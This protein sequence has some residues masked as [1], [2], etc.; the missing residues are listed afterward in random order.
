MINIIN[1][2]GIHIGENI[3]C[4]GQ[5]ICFESFNKINETVK[6]SV[7]NKKFFSLLLI[8]IF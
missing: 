3:H 8:F 1:I 6:K 7:K 4:Q 2:I 5:S